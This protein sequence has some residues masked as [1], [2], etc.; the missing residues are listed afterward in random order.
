MR[1]ILICIQLFFLTFFTYGQIIPCSL[2]GGS[3]YIDNNSNPRMMNASVNGLSMYSYFW[4]D[5][6][7]TVVSTS[8]QTQFYTQWCVTIIDNITG[9][10]TIICQDCFADTNALCM[11][12]MIYMP[13]CGC[14]GIMYPNSCVADC[15]DVAWTP[16]V[17]NGMPGGFLPCS[18]VNSLCEVEIN[19]DSIICNLGT[20]QILTASPTSSSLPF[21]SYIWDNG[22]TGPILTITTPGT[23]CVTA[24]DSTGCTSSDCVTLKV[25]DIPI[26]SVPSPPNICTGDTLVLEIDTIGLSNIVW[27]PNSLPTPPVHRIEFSPNFS[28]TSVVEAVDTGGCDRR[29]EIFI[30]VYAETPLNLMTFPNPPEVCFGDSL[31][32]EVN[33]SFVS[34]SWNTGNPLDQGEDRVVVYPNQDFN[35]V[36]EA[37]DSN[38]CESRE[39]I[40]VLVDTCVTGVNIA[41]FSE[42][43]IYPNPTSGKLYVDLPENEIFIISILN[44]EGK[45]ILEEREAFNSITIESEKLIKGSYVLRIGND[46]G[47]FNQIV[48][49]E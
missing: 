49:F 26:F 8:N 4:I 20:P 29:G 46:R 47:T 42:I 22:Q 7:G 31:V 36:V 38:G 40:L 37:L 43:S 2:T 12:P 1:T 30:D 33:Q 27:I 23:Y 45:L 3:V 41:M 18:L 16:A 6:N 48:I 9:C 13:V 34:Y 32:I 17:S 19:G 21:V 44:M 15:A 35:Y 25:Q 11:C 14:D 39:E 5:T 28:I 24:T 10:D